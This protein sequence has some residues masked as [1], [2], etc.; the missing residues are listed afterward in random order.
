MTVS[1]RDEDV[2]VGLA[3]S[4][5]SSPG[6]YAL[7]LGAGVSAPSGIP[8]AWGVLTDLTRR[9]AE[10]KG[11]E[12][13]DPVQ[14]FEEQYG[15]PPQY[16]TLLE[17]L[18]PT[19]L[20]RQRLLRAYFEPSAE[21]EAAGRKQ[22]TAAH[23][24][25]ARLA[26]MG[27]VKVI[28]TLN[29]DR[30][31][32]RA[33]RAEGVEPT[34]VASPADVAGMAPLHTLE[35]CVVHLH[36]DYL[37]PNSMLNITSE[38]AAY[39]PSTRKLLRRVLEDYGLIIAGWS[40]LYDPALREAIAAHYSTRFTLAWIE[41]GSV[42]DKARE[43]RLLKK[44]VLVPSDADTGFGKLADAVQALTAR[45]SRHPLTLSVAVETAKRE[46][47]GDRVAIGLHDTVRREFSRLHAHADFHLPNYHS[48][49][50]YGGYDAILDRVEES[51]TIC[52]GLVATLAYW[53]DDRTD[54]WWLEELERFST[55]ARG[56]GLSKLM[57]LRMVT[58]VSLL[59]AAGIAAVAARRYGLLAQ[60][61]HASRA[62][63][64]NGRRESLAFALTPDTF[65][66]ANRLHGFLVPIIREALA[67]GPESLDETWQLFELL[68][69]AHAAMAE[70]QFEELYAT[71]TTAPTPAALIESLGPLVRPARLHVLTA[72]PRL[73][74]RYRSPLAERL[75]DDL[76]T[77]QS[78]HPLVVSGYVRDPQALARMLRVVSAALGGIG[79]ELAWARVRGGGGFVPTSVW[80]DSGKTPEELGSESLA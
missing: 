61:F 29:F 52:C 47:S 76:E 24:A 27:A 71:L 23:E 7:L 43:L 53:G 40:S 42:P 49:D 67:T 50:P 51:S 65:G 64:Y 74:E 8:T 66:D 39:D 36:G 25:I 20:E 12:V 6:A 5:H 63:P 37:N 34:V 46:L 10:V 56:G 19:Q 57:E 59:Y 62:N 14:W 70:P 68:R 60:M 54:Y 4:L 38:L 78:T 35:C 9:F 21:D 15:Q 17:M 3:F 30:L 58:G 45:N 18:A 22:P 16:E 80:L 75:A 55:P 1:L 69:L 79:R 2:L 72:D 31:I 33:L 13:D 32:E 26:R 28:V 48:P 41:P 77:E 11:A 73:D 44:G